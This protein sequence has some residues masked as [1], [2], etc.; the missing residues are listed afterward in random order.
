[1]TQVIEPDIGSDLEF[2]RDTIL[3]HVFQQSSALG[4]PEITGVQAVADAQWWHGLTRCQGLGGTADTVGHIVT[5]TVILTGMDADH[6]PGMLAC[7]SHQ[8]MDHTAHFENIIDFFTDDIT[9]GNIRIACDHPQTLQVIRKVIIGC[10][11]ILDQGQRNPPDAGKKAQ[12]HAGLP[13]Y[14]RHDFMNL[15]EPGW[16]LRMFQQRGIRDLCVPDPVPAVFSGNPQKQVLI[17]RIPA[18]SRV[19]PVLQDLRGACPDIP[20]G[21]PFCTDPGKLCLGGLALG[22]HIAVQ[23]HFFQVLKHGLSILGYGQ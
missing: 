5:Q 20:V 3:A 2:Q 9:A 4:T 19:F 17:E 16:K 7:D 15:A 14:G 12:E 10:S 11:L 6:E 22:K 21:D 23:V 13:G 18:V 1:M 8:F